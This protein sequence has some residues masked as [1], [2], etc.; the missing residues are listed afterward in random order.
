MPNTPI[1]ITVPLE[2]PEC[3]TQHSVHFI[4]VY[5]GLEMMLRWRCRTCN[6]E[7]PITRKEPHPVPPAADH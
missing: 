5:E 7:W 4:T 1:S 6:H 3:H 2:C